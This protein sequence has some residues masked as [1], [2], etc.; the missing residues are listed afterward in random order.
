MNAE[1]YDVAVVGG[2]HNGLVAAAYCAQAGLRTILLERQSVLGGATLTEEVWPGYRVSVASYVCSLLDPRVIAD[3]DLRA[4]GF[5]AYRKDPAS[6]TPLADGRSLLLGSDDAANAREVAAFDPRDVAGLAAFEREATRLGALLAESF[7]D[8]APS[9]AKFDEATQTTLLGSAAALV[10]KF[11]RTPVLQATLATDGLIGTAAGPRDPGTAYVLAHHYAGHAMGAQG[12]W[13]FVRGGM[14]ALAQAI[15][16]AARTAGATLR[17]DADVAHIHVRNGRAETVEL[18]S[19]E[20]I[21]ARAILVGAAPQTLFLKLLDPSDAPPALHRRALNWRANGMAFKLNLA[22]GGVPDF[23]ARPSSE[24]APHHRATIHVAPSIAYLQRA[25]DD[26]RTGI[27]RDPMLECFMQTPT[28]P[29]LAP[30]GKHVMSIFAQYFPYERA[31]RA[32]TTADRTLIADRIV[33]TLAQYAPNLPALIEARQTLAAPDLETRIGLPGGQIFHG[34]LLPDQ[35]YEFR[36]PMRAGIPGLYL[37]GSGTHPGGCVSGF[38]GRR[39][40]A[41]AIADARV[42]ATA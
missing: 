7:A 22:L 40:A 2:G 19:G 28:E 16:G 14:G 26:T 39:A 21:S 3:L 35:I 23:T 38:P 1:T 31:D 9:L 32:W 15:A 42:A 10:E 18:S 29:E 20:R 13:G 5:A 41:A 4:H 24:L 34:E 36:F 8:P 11:V 12:A 27:S 17:T 33:S 25:F 30:P 6:F 37:C